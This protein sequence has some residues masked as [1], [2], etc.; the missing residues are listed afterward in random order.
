MVGDRWIFF[1]DECSGRGLAS[2]YWSFFLAVAG[3]CVNIVRQDRLHDL[4]TKS[5]GVG[6]RVILCSAQLNLFSS[7]VKSLTI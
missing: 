7:Q 5:I 3:E 1:H 2:L 6:T 4:E